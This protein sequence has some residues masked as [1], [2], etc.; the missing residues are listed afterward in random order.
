MLKECAYCK[1]KSA[2]G[3]KKCSACMEV[4]YCSRKCQK[5]DWKTHKK[6]C[7]KKATTFSSPERQSFDMNAQMDKKSTNLVDVMR[8]GDLEAVKV[9]I[10]NGADVNAVDKYNQTALHEAVQEGEGYVDIMKMLIQ[11]GADVNAVNKWKCTALY[12]AVCIG[13]VDIAKVL[14]QNGADVNTAY[15][16]GTTALHLVARAKTRHV[17]FEPM[18]PGL[19]RSLY[20]DILKR[21][22]KE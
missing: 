10:Q 6:V 21:T 13:Y 12:Y 17:D 16:N 14:V 7:C 11:N 3:F 19:R 4:Y 22:I 15:E 1:R 9:M 20:D 5:S 8:S 18:M 2:K